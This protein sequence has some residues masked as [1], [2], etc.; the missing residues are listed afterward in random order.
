MCDTTQNSLGFIGNPI[1]PL[2]KFSLEEWTSRGCVYTKNNVG[3]LLF[4][5]EF[6][7]F[8]VLRNPS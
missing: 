5:I 3:P 1:V 7:T 4:G 6:Y 2:W 8:A